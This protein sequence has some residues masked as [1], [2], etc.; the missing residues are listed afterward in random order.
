M[1][2]IH[3]FG[4]FKITMYFADHPPAHFH[5]IGDDFAAKMAIADLAIIAGALPAA[6][7]RRVVRWAEENRAMLETRWDELSG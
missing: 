1:P 3:D 7:R 2:T 6:M 5:V 4:A